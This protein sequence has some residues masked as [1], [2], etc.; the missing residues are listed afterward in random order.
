MTMAVATDGIQLDLATLPQTFVW[1]TGGNMTN[2][3]ISNYNGKD[4]TQ[5]FTYDVNNNVIGQSKWIASTHTG[6]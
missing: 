6:S 4:Y 1:S 3:I 2:I 5:T